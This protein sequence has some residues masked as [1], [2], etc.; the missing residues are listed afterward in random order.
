MFRKRARA[1]LLAARRI[2]VVRDD[3]LGDLVLALP[4]FSVLRAHC[5]RAELHLLCRPYAAALVDGLSVIDEVHLVDEAAGG[6]RRVLADG[7]FDA[8]FLPRIRGADYLSAWL[9]RIPLRIGSGYRL[10]SILLS[11]PVWDH[12]SDA[13]FHEAEY[14]TRMV[15]SVLGTPVPTELVR[16]RVDPDA[17]DRVLRRLSAAGV[18]PEDRV[19][20][21][22]P[23]SGGN[24]SQWPP[25]GFGALGARLGVSSRLRLVVTGIER[26]RALCDAVLVAGGRDVGAISLV[27]ELALPEMIALLDRSALVV[28]NSTGVLHVA[29]ALGVP[30][31]GL[32]PFAPPTRS[33]ARWGPYTR[34]ARILTPPAVTPEEMACITP[35]AAEA[36][37]R[38]LL[39]GSLPS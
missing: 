24:A 37:A 38:E 18:T 7:R 10:Y 25:E 11:H 17:R 33:A 2:V 32:Y 16:P 20:V 36:A 35:A 22:H 12:R 14:N 9:A 19:V 31:L 27:G 3:A 30:V 28:A 1:R 4:M 34:R 15:A 26:E 29:A 39:A 23:G 5:P 8:V 6:V 13:K 21:L